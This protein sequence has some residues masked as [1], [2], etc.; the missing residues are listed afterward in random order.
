MAVVKTVTIQIG[1]SDDKLTQD[2]WAEFVDMMD[3][4]IRRESG[5]VHFMGAPPNYLKWQNAAWVVMVNNDEVEGLKAAVSDVRLR[6]R[7]Q[8]AAFTVGIT[9]FV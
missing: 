3:T 7:Q 5:S 6:F 1:N 8:S 9:E 4:V 2:E